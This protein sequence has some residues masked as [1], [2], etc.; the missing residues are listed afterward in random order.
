MSQPSVQQTAEV[1]ERETRLGLVLYGGISL[2]IYMNGMAH[3][4]YRLVQ[5][6]GAYGL[7]KLLQDTD[8]VVDVVSGTSA[9]GLHGVFLAHALANNAVAVSTAAN[10]LTAIS[11]SNRTA[12]AGD[13]F[14][15]PNVAALTANP[16]PTNAGATKTS[17]TRCDRDSEMHAAP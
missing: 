13:S 9:G 16:R 7:L 8:V 2:A 4:F 15:C 6:R 10:E 17:I 1:F 14:R 3:E 5:G 11:V 12:I